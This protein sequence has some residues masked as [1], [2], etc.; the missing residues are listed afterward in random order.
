MSVQ[1]R[2]PVILTR[3]LAQAKRFARSLPSGTWPVFSPLLEISFLP[4]TEPPDVFETL[5]F[6]SE[7]GV[8]ALAA[9]GALRS[10][11][12]ALCVGQRTAEAAQAAG[13]EATS[14]NG[15]AVDLIQLA[16]SAPGPFVHVRGVHTRGDVAQMLNAAGHPCRELVVYDQI[17]RSLSVPATHTFSIGQPCLVPLFSPRTA[18]LFLKA[19]P[20]A[21]SAHL[22]CLSPAIT[23][24]VAAG[25]YG[26][27]STSRSPTAEALMS[28][29]SSRLTAIR[30]ETK[31][32]SG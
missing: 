23:E 9:A 1:H 27:L 31:G 12:T 3:A 29:L 7:N 16:L 22:I 10:G 32:V 24:V 26:S 11:Q 4:V 14:A 25:R 13:L 30:L 6:T 15:A 17:E 19:Q 8:M 21:P 20:E 2:V 28:E 18:A 5:L